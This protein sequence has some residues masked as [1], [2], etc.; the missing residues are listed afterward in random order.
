MVRSTFQN[1]SSSQMLL[2]SLS[3]ASFFR[4]YYNRIRTFF[5]VI[6]LFYVGFYPM[7]DDP[8]IHDDMFALGSLFFFLMPIMDFF[9]HFLYPRCF[10]SYHSFF[11]S[12]FSSRFHFVFSSTPFL[13]S[14]FIPLLS[15]VSSLLRPFPFPYLFTTL[16][17]STPP[18][19]YYS[20]PFHSP[21]SLL[22]RPFPLHLFATPSLSSPPSLCYSVPFLSHS[23][24]SHFF[25]LRQI[26][27]CSPPIPLRWA[28]GS[29]CLRPAGLPCLRRPIRIPWL[30]PPPT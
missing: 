17:L 29:P 22:L 7:N 14:S 2:S 11:F 8:V 9:F 23:F 25:S 27:C 12:F 3:L 21:I 26:L 6:S 30:P 1:E 13:L 18:S 24:H 10:S 15:P 28:V 5:F 16:S 19:L 4:F 20:V